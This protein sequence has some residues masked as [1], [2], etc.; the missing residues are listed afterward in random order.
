MLIR[1]W[2]EGTQPVA[3]TA[4]TERGE[5]VTFD[6]W[7]ELLRV[8]AELVAAAGGEDVQAVDS[9]VQGNEPGS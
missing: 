7:L 3:G 9:T 2:I 1:I 6:G 8:L 5:P 4:V